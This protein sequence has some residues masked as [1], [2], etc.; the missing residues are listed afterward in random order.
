MAITSSKQCSRKKR[1][2]GVRE[3]AQVMSMSLGGQRTAQR[4]WK[5]GG[6][7]TSSPVRLRLAFVFSSSNSYITR[8]LC[9]S[10]YLCDGERERERENV[11]SR[12]FQQTSHE[13]YLSCGMG[14]WP[15]EISMAVIG[16][17]KY[18][19]FLC[20]D[21]SRFPSRMCNVIQCLL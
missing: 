3:W 5:K 17:L 6:E 13:I 8:S 10:N 1:K 19:K 7:A 2:E 4:F 11:Q 16:A 18:Q 14:V 12:L 9:R 21:F 20:T 15:G